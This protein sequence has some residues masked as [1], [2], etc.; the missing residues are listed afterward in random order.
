M[1]Q[2]SSNPSQQIGSVP[3]ILDYEMSVVTV[4]EAPRI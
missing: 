2:S 1:I 4:I 3:T